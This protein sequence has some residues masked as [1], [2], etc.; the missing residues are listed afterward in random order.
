MPRSPPCLDV[1]RDAVSS[2]DA[3][4]TCRTLGPPPRPP[5]RAEEMQL[6]EP[7]GP[8]SADTSRVDVSHQLLLVR[9]FR[10]VPVAD[11]DAGAADER[12]DLVLLGPDVDVDL[13]MRGRAR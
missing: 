6:T 9:S 10:G 12:P 2:A 1:V 4:A 3:P 8:G 5:E 13:G 7:G 11:Q